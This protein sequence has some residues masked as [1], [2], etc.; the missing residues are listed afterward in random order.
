MGGYKYKNL[1]ADTEIL[2]GWGW[3]NLMSNWI[4]VGCGRGWERKWEER[5]WWPQMPAFCE[6]LPSFSARERIS[7]GTRRASTSTNDRKSV[8]P[9]SDWGRGKF[10]SFLSFTAEPLATPSLSGLDGKLTRSTSITWM[11]WESGHLHWCWHFCLDSCMIFYLSCF[12][13]GLCLG[14]IERWQRC[15]L[16]DP[17]VCWGDEVS[18]LF[19]SLLTCKEGTQWSVWIASVSCV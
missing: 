2:Q 4:S 6:L 18:N 13:L 1:E 7:L 14:G 5:A 11:W 19:L 17:R 12:L 15:D 3:E 10:F 16:K 8:L 9:V